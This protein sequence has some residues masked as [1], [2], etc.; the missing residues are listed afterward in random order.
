MRCSLSPSGMF[1]VPVAIAPG[2]RCPSAAAMTEFGTCQVAAVSGVPPSSA[3]AR[4]R[5]TALTST[6]IFGIVYVDEPPNDHCHGST[7][8]QPRGLGPACTPVIALTL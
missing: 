1:V 8:W 4:D 3:G 6:S 5:S 7:L 2:G